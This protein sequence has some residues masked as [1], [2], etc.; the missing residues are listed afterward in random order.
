MDLE[1]KEKKRFPSIFCFLRIDSLENGELVG[2]EVIS[3]E[4]LNQ[5]GTGDMGSE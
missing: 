2:L 3:L 5:M 4:K 1:D